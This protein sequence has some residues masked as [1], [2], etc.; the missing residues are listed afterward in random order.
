MFFCCK[1]LNFVDFGTKLPE[2][3]FDSLLTSLMGLNMFWDYSVLL[4]PLL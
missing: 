2:L 3:T 1:L 4:L